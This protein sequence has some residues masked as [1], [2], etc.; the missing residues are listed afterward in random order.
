MNKFIPNNEKLLIF[1]IKI[2][3][4]SVNAMTLWGEKEEW[5]LEKLLS[6]SKEIVEVYGIEE[7]LI[8]WDELSDET[9]SYRRLTQ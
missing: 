8:N 5:K 7:A 1:Q 2:K 9:N 3:T 4:L 6:Y